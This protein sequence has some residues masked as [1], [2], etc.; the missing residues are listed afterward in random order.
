MRNVYRNYIVNKEIY[1]AFFTKNDGDEKKIKNV[2]LVKTFQRF[3]TVSG[4]CVNCDQYIHQ[5][6]ASPLPMADIICIFYL[7]FSTFLLIIYIH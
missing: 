2:R 4:A 5:F 3:S 6:T 7:P 1:G